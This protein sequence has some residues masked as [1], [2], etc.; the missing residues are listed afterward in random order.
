MVGA[1]STNRKKRTVSD[2][3]PALRSRKK[4]TIA[5]TSTEKRTASTPSKDSVKKLT[6]KENEPNNHS[7]GDDKENVLLTPSVTPYWKVCLLA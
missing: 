5:A 4:T 3:S 7:S 2:R 6:G 1:D